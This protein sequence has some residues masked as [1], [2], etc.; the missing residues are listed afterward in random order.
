MAK[1]QKFRGKCNKT[2]QWQ[3]GFGYCLNTKEEILLLSNK[4]VFTV[5]PESLGEYVTTLRDVNWKSRELFE[6]DIIRYCSKDSENAWTIPMAIVWGGD[7]YP[8]FDL[9][10]NPFDHNLIWML[11]ATDEY[12]IEL[13]GNIFEN[14]ELL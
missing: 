2:N 6:G 8:A 9:E 11:A 13:L 7:K 12:D 5:Y 4:G 10:D 1:E 14:P 3:Y